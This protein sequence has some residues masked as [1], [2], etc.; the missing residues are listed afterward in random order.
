MRT[1]DNPLTSRFLLSKINIPLIKRMLKEELAKNPLSPCTMPEQ[2]DTYVNSLISTINIAMNFA[3]PRANISLK[4]VPRFDEKCKEV[5]MKARRLKKI[6]KRE[7]T[8]ESWENFRLAEAEKRRVIVKAKKAAYRKSREEACASPEDMWKAIRN[9]QNRAPRQAF[10]PD[11]RISDGGYATKLRDKLEELKKVLL[12]ATHSADL[13]DIL[14]FQY[15]NNLPMPRITKK[16]LLQI[17]KHLQMNK[18]SRPDQIPNEVL[19]FIMPEISDYL[20]QIFNDSLS[21]GYYPLHFK[22]S[23]VVILHKPE[24]AK[25]YTS[26]KS[27]RPISL[28]NTLEKIIE[29]V[30][31]TRI[32]YMA[33]THYLLLKTHVGG[34]R[35]SCIETTIHHLLEKIYAV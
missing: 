14:N 32:S 17:G 24:G 13:S 34:R 26:P 27:Y 9:T 18:A 5:Q 7:E 23:I 12:P 25:D 3:I 15:S 19:K 22:E 16:E 6:W 30:L 31:A 33:I 20:V 2:L 10:L 35:G 1:I 21:I 28:L 11:I 4:S 29:A 8:E